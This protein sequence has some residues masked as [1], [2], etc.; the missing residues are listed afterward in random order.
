M[1]VLVSDDI[2]AE[3][4]YYCIDNCKDNLPFFNAGVGKAYLKDIDFFLRFWKKNNY[5]AKP[6]VTYI[7]EKN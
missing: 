2:S 1:R 3:L 5:H 4:A 7:G 6:L